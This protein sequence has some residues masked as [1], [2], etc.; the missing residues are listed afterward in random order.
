MKKAQGRGDILGKG[1]VSG[2]RKKSW[3]SQEGMM[4]GLVLLRTSP[5][6]EAED[7]LAIGAVAGPRQLHVRDGELIQPGDELE[8]CAHGR[9]CDHTLDQGTGLALW[10]ASGLSLIFGAELGMSNCERFGGEMVR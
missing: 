4:H 2:I 8:A 7:G 3:E 6:L 1:K 5:A 9:L 10:G